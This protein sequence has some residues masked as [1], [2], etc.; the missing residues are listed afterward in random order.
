MQ[1]PT[2]V[3]YDERSNFKDY[4][5]QA[6]G[7]TELAR[8]KKGYVI[9]ANGEVS[10]TKRPLGIFTNYPEVR[11]G[12]TIVV[13]EKPETLRLT[14]QERVS[15]YSAIVSTASLIVTTIIQISR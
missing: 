1:H 7:F 12:A 14:P 5:S 3:R 2:T 15:L 9:Y 11:P 10:Q 6:G 4:I 13:P 8:D